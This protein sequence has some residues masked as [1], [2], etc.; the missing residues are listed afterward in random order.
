[1]DLARRPVVTLDVRDHCRRAAQ[2]MSRFQIRHLPVLNENEQLRE[3]QEQMEALQ[4]QS[5]E[6]TKQSLKP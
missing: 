6:Q 5:K 3:L 2:L 4:K 1:M